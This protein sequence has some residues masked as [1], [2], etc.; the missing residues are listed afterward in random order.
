MQLV[1]EAELIGVGGGLQA[2]GGGGW[3]R[4]ECGGAEL[5]AH[6]LAHTRTR[7]HAV[8]LV[9]HNALDTTIFVRILR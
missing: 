1:I 7:S 8:D 9:S 6:V 2:V 4:A 5:Q 3:A